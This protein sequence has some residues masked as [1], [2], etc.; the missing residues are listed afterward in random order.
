MSSLTVPYLQLVP[1]V[2]VATLIFACLPLALI[3]TFSVFGCI[4]KGPFVVDSFA[5]GY[6]FVVNCTLSCPVVPDR[7]Q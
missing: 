1:V 6:L 7:P 3:E 4:I 2:E 5:S